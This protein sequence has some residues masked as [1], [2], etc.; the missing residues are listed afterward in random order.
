ME[1]FQD[2]S[3][4]SLFIY[5]FTCDDISTCMDIKKKKKRKKVMLLVWLLMWLAVYKHIMLLVGQNAN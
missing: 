2:T 1:I 5:F 4:P 3:F